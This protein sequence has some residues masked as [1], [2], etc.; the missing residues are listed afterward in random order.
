MFLAISYLK[1]LEFQ[2]IPAMNIKYH[3]KQL[4]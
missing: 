4:Q 1:L 3:V 2:T